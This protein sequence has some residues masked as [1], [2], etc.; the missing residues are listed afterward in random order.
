MVA[1]VRVHADGCF[2][3]FP[4][5]FPQSGPVL[6]HGAIL[7][8]SKPRLPLCCG[9]G[10]AGP[11]LGIGAEHWAHVVLSCWESSKGRG[12]LTG[13][14]LALGLLYPVIMEN[15]PILALCQP[16]GLPPNL[17]HHWSLFPSPQPKSWPC[18]P[19]AS[20]KNGKFSK[21][22][23]PLCLWP[24]LSVFPDGSP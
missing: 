18:F 16:S 10:E 7:V 6:S 2:L 3:N 22:A 5:S 15:N 11:V 8:T 4:E 13:R 1:S 17:G 24:C 12:P 23:P 9:R 21:A 20:T 14:V 19:K